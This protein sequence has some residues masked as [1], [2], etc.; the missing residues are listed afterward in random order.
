[1]LQK[2][3]YERQSPLLMMFTESKNQT[4]FTEFIC[5]YEPPNEKDAGYNNERVSN[6]KIRKF[7]SSI[8]E[9]PES[10]YDINSE[11][12]PHQYKKA[13]G[14]IKFNISDKIMCLYTNT[15]RKYI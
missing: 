11:Y 7:D 9:F 6:K 13:K 15:K 3:K 4:H 14:N 10:V 2:G 8:G 5:Q 12:I 1:M